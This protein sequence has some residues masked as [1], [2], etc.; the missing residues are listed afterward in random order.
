M[1]IK[2]KKKKHFLFILLGLFFLD[3]IKHIKHFS[4]KL[5][6][7]NL[8]VIKLLKKKLKSLVVMSSNIFE[9]LLII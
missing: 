4:L 6:F 5:A 8:H 2:I 7:Y 9:L 1:T 3:H